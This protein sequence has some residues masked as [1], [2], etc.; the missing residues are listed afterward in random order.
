MQIYRV[1]NPSTSYDL[2]S[3][4]VGCVL[5]DCTKKVSRFFFFFFNFTSVSYAKGYLLDG[6][7]DLNSG[8]ETGRS[9]IGKGVQE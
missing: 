7:D 2:I 9:K 6:R 5:F 3:T 8:E 1:L 4:L